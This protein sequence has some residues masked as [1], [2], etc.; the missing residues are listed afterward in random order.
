MNRFLLVPAVGCLLAFG[1]LYAVFNGAAEIENRSLEPAATSP[2][3]SVA[4]S[5]SSSAALPEIE[6]QRMLDSLGEAYRERRRAYEESPHR[7]YSRVSLGPLAEVRLEFALEQPASAGDRFVLATVLLQRDEHK[8]A[9]P[10][11]LDPTTQQVRMFQE[12]SWQ[13][14]EQ[15]LQTAPIGA[16]WETWNTN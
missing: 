10:C 1:S 11:V 9:V 14:G 13:T 15:W 4:S 12:G 7:R 6:A 3:A 2:A 5:E 16:R 8:I